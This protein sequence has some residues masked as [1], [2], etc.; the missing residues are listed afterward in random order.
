M[1]SRSK[2]TS[3]KCV[4][5]LSGY[6]RC[7]VR[8]AICITSTGTLADGLSRMCLESILRPA[9]AGVL[10]EEL[11]VRLVSMAKTCPLEWYKSWR[12]SLDELHHHPVSLFSH[13]FI[14]CTVPL[15]LPPQRLCSRLPLSLGAAQIRTLVKN[16]ES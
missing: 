13:Q 15:L 16:G 5:A 14:P 12:P 10:G 1:T 7:Y 8:A 4:R 3:A 9:S 2:G 6:D 11:L